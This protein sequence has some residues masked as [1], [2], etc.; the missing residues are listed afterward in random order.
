MGWEMGISH[1]INSGVANLVF[2]YLERICSVERLVA[3]TEARLPEM[4]QEVTVLDSTE[5]NNTIQDTLTRPMWTTAPCKDMASSNMIL[6]ITLEAKGT[7]ANCSS[8]EDL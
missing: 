5:I 4:S 3:S 8:M 2:R 6:E 1:K 7:E